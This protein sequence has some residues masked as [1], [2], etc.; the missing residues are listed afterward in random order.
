MNGGAFTSVAM[1]DGGQGSFSGCIPAQPQP[2]VVEYYITAAD[3]AGNAGFSPAAA[4][5]AT[6]DTSGAATPP[7]YPVYHMYDVCH[8]YDD[9]EAVGDWVPHAAGSTASGGIW[10]NGSPS[11]NQS[12][13]GYDMT[14]GSGAR[15]FVTGAAGGNVNNGVTIL[16][17]PVWDL[18]GHD[19]VVVKL[20]RWF[21]NDLD[22]SLDRFRQDYFLIDASND[23]GQT[24]TNL[25]TTNEGLDSWQEREF[26]LSDVFGALGMVRF[27]FVAQDTGATTKVEALVDEVRIT[28]KAPVVVSVP[29]PGD[30]IAGSVPARFALHANE[31]NPFNP[32]TTIRYDL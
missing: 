18:A 25:E 22:G 20:R 6:P 29:G 26:N 11:A 12:Q 2:S 1:A 4:E 7:T 13:P 32:R 19:S 31:P 3:S 28:A 17:S 24:W 9:C 8:I 23:S 15:C 30:G 5:D 27:R 21:V 14:P 16:L 10:E